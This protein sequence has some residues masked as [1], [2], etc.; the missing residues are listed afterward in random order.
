MICRYCLFREAQTRSTTNVCA[1]CYRYLEPIAR[2]APEYFV[3]LRSIANLR[4]ATREAVALPPRPYAV[5][6]WRP[7]V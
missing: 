6:S 4:W 2:E 5:R 3:R 7:A 1:V